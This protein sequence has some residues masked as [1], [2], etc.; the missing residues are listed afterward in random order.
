MSSS[1]HLVATP[2]VV[3]PSAS[4]LRSSIQRD[5]YLNDP[6]RWA[7]ERLGANLWSKQRE[8]I[9][10]IRDNRRTVVRSCHAVGKSFV[11]AIIATW[12]IECH[13]PGEAFVVTSAPTAAQVRAVLWREINRA[14]AK[15]KLIGRT[16]QTEWWLQ[17]PNGEEEMVGL[18]RKPGN[19]DTSAFQGIHQKY[20][21]VIFDEACGIHTQLW[22][23]GD[24]LISNKGGRIVALGNPD[25]P[26]TEFEAVSKPGS[27]WNSIQISAF[28]TPNFTGEPI[29]DELRHSLISP[30]W[31]H[32]KLRKWGADNPI[33]ISKILGEFPDTTVDGLIPVKYIRQ[34]QDAELEPSTPVELGV[35]VGGGGDKTSICLRRGDV[36]R[37]IRR[38][39]NPDTMQTLGNI[40]SDVESNRATSARVDSIGIGRGVKDR[41]KEIANDQSKHLDTRRIAATVHGVNVGNAA[42]DNKSY[43]NLRAEGFWNLRERFVEGRIDIDPADDDLAA[44]LVD[45]RYKRS[46]GRIQVESK[47]DM[48]RRGKSSPDD[49]DALMLST[50]DDTVTKKRTRVTWGAKRQ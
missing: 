48:K 38:D 23:S 27:G 37:I 28:D 26:E 39:R 12:W 3:L 50:L 18:G 14:H 20:V 4:D 24:S 32:E 36:F 13:K 8:I 17:M 43:I 35:D 33:Y 42:I 9:E 40:L 16:N 21:L 45:I 10:S 47:D 1:P 44:Q 34:A 31:A 49:A 6:V 19:M 22:D 25:V 46:A 15:G 30:I 29:P 5:E 41:A 2:R 7:R 11:S